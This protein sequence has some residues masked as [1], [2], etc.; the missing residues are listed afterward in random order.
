MKIKIYTVGGTIDKIY[1]EIRNQIRH[2]KT[3]WRFIACTEPERSKLFIQDLL[4][5]KIKI[6][7][8]LEL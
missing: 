5:K 6:F 3:R 8:G 1:N 2:T 4:I 7:W